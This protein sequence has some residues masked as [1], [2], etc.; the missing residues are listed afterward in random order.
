MKVYLSA[1]QIPEIA[2][3]TSE[4]RK[5]VLRAWSGY[6]EHEHTSEHYAFYIIIFITVIGLNEVL[7]TLFQMTFMARAVLSLAA[8]SIPFWIMRCRSLKLLS[9]K[10]GM[11]I[12]QTENK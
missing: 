12:R 7:N 5:A 9:E 1:R 10:A 3:L 2:N 8:A 4:H 6:Y 11:I